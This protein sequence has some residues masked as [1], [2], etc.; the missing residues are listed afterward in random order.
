MCLTS[1]VQEEH[2][3]IAELTP[4]LPG[5]IGLSLYGFLENVLTIIFIYF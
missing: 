3:V 1:L 5:N 4:G 2:Y